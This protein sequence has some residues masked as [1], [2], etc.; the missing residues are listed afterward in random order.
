MTCK[1]L[2][3]NEFTIQSQRWYPTSLV[4]SNGSVLVMGGSKGA[5][6]TINP[7]LEIL[8]QIS[9]GD[10]QVYLDYI[11]RT[12]PNNLYPFLHVLPSGRIFV[13]VFKEPTSLTFLINTHGQGITTRHVFL[14]RDHSTPSS[15]FPTSL[16]LS[17]AP[18]QV[19]LARIKVHPYSCPNMLPTRTQS[20]SWSVVAPTLGLP[21]IIA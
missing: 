4:L 13:G 12:A 10:T 16:V 2:V 1:V 7:T 5:N 15:N 20:L 8:P 9:G 3:L 11:Q 14:T 17:I 18:A 6:G 19:E 21:W